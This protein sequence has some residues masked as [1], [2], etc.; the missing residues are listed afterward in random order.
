MKNASRVLFLVGGI[1]SCVAVFIYFIT[2]AVY[3]N[4]EPSNI[5]FEG[6]GVDPEVMKAI[7]QGIGVFF[8]II[9]IFSIA[10]IILAFIARNKESKVLFVLNIIFGFLSC[11][12]VNSVG[13]ILALI[14]SNRVEE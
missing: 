12:I 1:I 9:G 8:L 13:G 5:T 10:N 7:A 3:L 2:A 6:P 4:Y 14:A 11:C